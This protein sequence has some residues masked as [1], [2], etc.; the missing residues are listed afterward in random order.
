MWAL[1]LTSRGGG[2]VLLLA[3]C[4]RPLGRTRC[5]TFWGFGL[6]VPRSNASGTYPMYAD[7]QGVFSNNFASGQA[8]SGDADQRCPDCLL[9]GLGFATKGT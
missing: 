5:G 7:T 2:I 1:T 3:H 9:V 8:V 6:A 4:R